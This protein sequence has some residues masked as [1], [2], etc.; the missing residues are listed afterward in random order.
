MIGSLAREGGLQSA[1]WAGP[2][3]MNRPVELELGYAADD[4][5]YLVDLGLPVPA[6]SMPA[7]SLFGRD[8]VIKRE[9]IFTG[10]AMRPASTLV[11][12]SGPLAEKRRDSGHGFEVLTRGLPPYR[13]VLTELANP[14]QLAE[15]AAVRERLRSWRSPCCRQRDTARSRAKVLIH[16][17]GILL[18][19]V[20]CGMR[21]RCTRFGR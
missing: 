5:G 21:R 4:V 12:R 11:R 6:T 14:D 9:V 18:V 15:L 19:T 13:S 7:I 2:V 3:T 1:R 17:D 20:A 8:P 16:R 10:P